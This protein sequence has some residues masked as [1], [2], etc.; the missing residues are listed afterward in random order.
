MECRAFS[1]V[2]CLGYQVHLLYRQ[3]YVDDKIKDPSRGEKAVKSGSCQH[4]NPV[5]QDAQVAYVVV[6]S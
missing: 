6:Q 2:A 3:L 5:K 1:D 4:A